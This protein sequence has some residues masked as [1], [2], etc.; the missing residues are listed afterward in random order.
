MLK[1][2][3]DPS[4]VKCVFIYTVSSK[5]PTTLLVTLTARVGVERVLVNCAWCNIVGL[6]ELTVHFPLMK[7]ITFDIDL[8]VDLFNITIT[9]A[10]IIV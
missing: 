6:F 5:S 1:L 2:N 9:K 10:I 8:K 7:G 3:V 4:C